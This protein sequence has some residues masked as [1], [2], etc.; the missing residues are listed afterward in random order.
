MR[1]C[2]KKIYK[3]KG[4]GGFFTGIG[5]FIAS[6]ISYRLLLIQA[7]GLT[8]GIRNGLS[9]AGSKAVLSVGLMYAVS[10][11]LYPVQTVRARMIVG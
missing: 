10:L 6:Q 9:S 7:F 2:V 1:D 11:I 8:A 4:L 5:T 3:K